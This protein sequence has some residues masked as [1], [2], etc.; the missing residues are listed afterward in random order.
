[1]SVHAG[2]TGNE[3]ADEKAKR[4]LEESIPN[5]LKYPPDDISGLIKTEIVGSWQ[6]KW[7]ERDNA[8][9]EKKK[10]TIWQNDTEKLKKRDHVVHNRTLC[11]ETEEERRKSN[12][13]KKVWEKKEEGAKMLVKYVK[14]CGLNYNF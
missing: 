4:A 13:T 3:E 5:D 11:K 1:V 7:E 6:R 10:T 12:M 14:N 9:K 8:M 2:I